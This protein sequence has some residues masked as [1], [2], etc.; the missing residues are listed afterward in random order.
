MKKLLIPAIIVVIA[1]ILFSISTCCYAQGQTSGSSKEVIA[2]ETTMEVTP[3]GK[4]LKVTTDNE[5]VAQILIKTFSPTHELKYH[6]SY[7]KDR[8]GYYPEWVFYFQTE[9]RQ[10]I[11]SA[12]K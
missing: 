5:T 1:S 6:F 12:L 8:K 4:T 2:D 11:L 3:A 7:K 10:S 9:K